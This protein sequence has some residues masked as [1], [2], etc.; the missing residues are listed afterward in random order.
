MWRS[1]AARNSA[2]SVRSRF[3]GLAPGMGMRDA[4]V[5]TLLVQLAGVVLTVGLSTRLPRVVR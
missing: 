5:V 4:L 2:D 1:Q 3:L